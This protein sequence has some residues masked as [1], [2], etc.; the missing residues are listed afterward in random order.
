MTGIQTKYLGPTEKR[1]ARIVA[2]T[3]SDKPIRI[4]DSYDASMS[5]Y[6]NHANM[7]RRLAEK[8]DW[9]GDYYSCNTPNGFIFVCVINQKPEFKILPRR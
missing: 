9:T 3:T 2:W 7:A 5:L 1:T 6:E 8:L 4:T